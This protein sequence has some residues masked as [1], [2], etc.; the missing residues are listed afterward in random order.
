MRRFETTLLFEIKTNRTTARGDSIEG[1]IRDI[2]TAR[3]DPS[4][5]LAFPNQQ[6]YRESSLSD[7]VYAEENCKGY[8]MVR[9]QESW[10]RVNESGVRLFPV[11]VAVIDDGIYRWENCCEFDNATI[12]TTVGGDAFAPAVLEE[13]LPGFEMP[14]AT[15]TGRMTLLPQKPMTGACGSSV[16]AHL[17]PIRI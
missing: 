16:S 12:N 8:E 10:D 14:G 4:I 17:V 1:L 9:V 7:S 5:E 11:K 3:E 6:I 13:P 15:G 2:A